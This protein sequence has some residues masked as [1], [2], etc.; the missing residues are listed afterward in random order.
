MIRASNAGRSAISMPSTI[1]RST[2]RVIIARNN[3]PTK[4]A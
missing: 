1:P 3:T 4:P 2:A